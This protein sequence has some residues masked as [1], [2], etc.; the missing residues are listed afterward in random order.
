MSS[1]TPHL[2]LSLPFHFHPQVLQPHCRTRHCSCNAAGLCTRHC[3]F[4]FSV[5][6]KWLV[7]TII[8]STIMTLIMIIMVIMVLTA[9]MMGILILPRKSR[10]GGNFCSW[11]CSVRINISQYFI[12]CVHTSSATSVSPPSS[13]GRCYTDMHI[14]PP[15]VSAVAFCQYITHPCLPPLRLQ[16]LLLLLL[17]QQHTQII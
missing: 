12:R 6:G 9:V 14:A 8:V 3:L 16:L 7:I 17:K 13:V 11:I 5:K 2:A 1:V 10:I 4:L 15:C